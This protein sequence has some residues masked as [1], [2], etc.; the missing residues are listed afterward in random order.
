MEIELV[1]PISIEV[2]KSTASILYIAFQ[3]KGRYYFL[4][5]PG[6]DDF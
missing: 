4:I 6:K 1:Y 3:Y 5:M 2:C